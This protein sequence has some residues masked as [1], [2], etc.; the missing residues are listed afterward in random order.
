M[1]ILVQRNQ[2]VVGPTLCGVGRV[3]AGSDQLAGTANKGPVQP[4]V[5]AIVSSVPIR[6]DRPLVT[7]IV[8]VVI[9]TSRPDVVHINVFQAEGKWGAVRPG[10]PARCVS[11]GRIQGQRG[12]WLLD[13]QKV[14]GVAEEV[15]GV[16]EEHPHQTIVNAGPQVVHRLDS[17]QWHRV[18]VGKI[19]PDRAGKRPRR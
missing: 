16:I 5:V 12:D 15:A 2:V 14:L 6:G 8:L 18:D 17:K 13:G 9:G 11:Q 10:S 19:G 7:E 4:G 1:T 3:P